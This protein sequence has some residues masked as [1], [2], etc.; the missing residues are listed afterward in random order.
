MTSG[1]LRLAA[2]RADTS[3]SLRPA[4]AV[5]PSEVR[6]VAERLT[7]PSRELASMSMTGG[8]L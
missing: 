5:R 7:L 8:P 1:V 2:E 3:S 4:M 6:A